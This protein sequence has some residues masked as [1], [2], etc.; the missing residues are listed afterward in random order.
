M[1]RALCGRRLRGGPSS[2]SHHRLPVRQRVDRRDACAH[3][4]VCHNAE[5]DARKPP[6][7]SAAL[8]VHAGQHSPRCAR[9]WD[10][11]RQAAPDYVLYRVTPLARMAK[12]NQSHVTSG[13]PPRGGTGEGRAWR[14]PRD[15]CVGGGAGA[16][17]AIV[18]PHGQRPEAQ[19]GAH[20][21]R[22]R[23]LVV[24]GRRRH[25]PPYGWEDIL[26]AAQQGELHH[27]FVTSDQRRPCC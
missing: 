14:A 12:R 7:V 25:L 1:V 27:R 19:G 20:Q 21:R 24:D 16:R 23:R 18:G 6:H 26:A 11:R 17:A 15:R 9:C 2:H 10:V 3:A 8:G 22:R 5:L 4:A 13:V